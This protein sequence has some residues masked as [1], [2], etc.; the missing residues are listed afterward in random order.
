MTNQMKPEEFS[1]KSETPVSAFTTPIHYRTWDLSHSN[2]SKEHRVNVN[3][4]RKVRIPLL[5]DNITLLFLSYRLLDY[6]GKQ[7]GK[8]AWI[9][10]SASTSNMAKKIKGSQTF[11]LGFEKTGMASKVIHQATLQR[12]TCLQRSIQKTQRVKGNLLGLLAS[13]HK[14]R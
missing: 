8:R 5:A 9:L 14:K 7:Q 6:E 2:T 12:G 13:I 3:W 4:K 11:G 10:A 1:L